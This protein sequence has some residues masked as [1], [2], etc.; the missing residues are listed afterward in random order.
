MTSPARLR[1]TRESWTDPTAC[2]RRREASRAAW[3]R[4][5]AQKP[6]PEPCMWNTFACGCGAE[7]VGTVT[8]PRLCSNCRAE[9]VA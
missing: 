5:K 2:E 7:C 9:R 4:R 6:P 8:G 1:A 3:V